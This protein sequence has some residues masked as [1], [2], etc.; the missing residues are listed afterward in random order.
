M[1]KLAGTHKH[2]YAEAIRRVEVDGV[3]VKEW[4]AEAGITPNNA[5]V[6]LFR[7]REAL[8]KQ[9]MRCCGTCASHGCLDC[10]CTM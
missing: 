3:P 1:Q 4:A 8:R 2:E 5:G 7:A 9:V 10:T 6:R